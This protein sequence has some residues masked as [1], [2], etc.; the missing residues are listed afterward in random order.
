MESFNL[1][2]WFNTL[3]LLSTWM[4]WKGINGIIEVGTF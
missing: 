2:L 3:S 4:D 1:A